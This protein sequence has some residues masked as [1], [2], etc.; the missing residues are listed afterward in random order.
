MSIWDETIG[1]T[2]TQDKQ[3]VKPD[4]DAKLT[5][6]MKEFQTTSN[7]VDSLK[8]KL[9]VIKEE[10]LDHFPKEP[11]KYDRVSTGGT[12]LLEVSISERWKW[13]EKQLEQLVDSDELP[14]YVKRRLTVDKRKFERLEA[15]EQ[16][17]YLDALTREP[18]LTRVAVKTI[19]QDDVS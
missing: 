10:I 16:D 14:L 1:S 19:P 5:G 12:H 6:L 3:A 7:L 17:R 18:G 2:A 4:V 15:D 11:G 8:E 9:D 13:D